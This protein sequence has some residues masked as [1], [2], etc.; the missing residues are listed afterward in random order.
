MLALWQRRKTGRGQY[1]DLAQIESSTCL[2]GEVVLDYSMNKRNP[3]RLG[4]GHAFMAPHGCYRCRGEDK[5]VTIAISTDEEWQ[6]FCKAIG[7]PPWTRD[8]KFSNQTGRWHNQEELD[9]LVQEWTCRQGH[10]EAMRIL[11]ESGVP[12]G[13]VLNARELLEDPQLKDRKYFIEQAHLS[14]GTRLYPGLPIKF[15]DLAPDYRRPAPRVDEHTDY[16]FGGLLGMS[17][18]EIEALQTRGV[19][20]NKTPGD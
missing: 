10:Y 14:V 11:Q 3:R 6:A 19:I 7:G 17:G 18:G 4:N 8:P 9:K 2:L 16:V 20:G 1:I 13:A 5:W 12:A 15:S